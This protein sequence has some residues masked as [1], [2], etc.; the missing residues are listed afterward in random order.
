LPARAS[1]RRWLRPSVRTWWAWCRSR[2]T[3]VVANVLGMI[4]SKPEGLMFEVTATDRRS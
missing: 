4:V 1:A 3:V 2:S